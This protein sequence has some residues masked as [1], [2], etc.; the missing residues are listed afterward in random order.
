MK[1]TKKTRG[2]PKKQTS[3]LNAELILKSAKTLL[4]KEKKLPSIRK[5]AQELEIDPMSIYYYFPN[6]NSL[7]EAITIS[8]MT[9]IYEPRK[10]K[11]LWKKELELLCQSYLKLL[12]DYPELLEVMLKME[13]VGPAN[14]FIKYLESIL[15]PLSLNEKD[16]Y[17]ALCLLADYLHGFAFSMQCDS[18]N[19]L[20]VEDSS[21][22]LKLYMNAIENLSS[23]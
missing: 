23:K 16:F 22:P 5:I 14:V 7:L 3:T 19:I 20:K 8:L 2:R 18:K 6:K 9:N 15:N 11:C 13:S 10:D 4:Q 1:D 12:D 21:E 17:S